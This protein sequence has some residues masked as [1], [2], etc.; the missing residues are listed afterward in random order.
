MKDRNKN[1]LLIILI[2]GILS[3]TIAYASLSTKLNIQG[4]AN[5]PAASWNIHFQNWALDTN[6][7]VNGRVNR[8]E[9]P[10][11]GQLT[12]SLSPN[13]TKIDDMIVTFNAPGD[14]VKYTFQIKNSGSINASL[15]NFE[16]NLTCNDEDCSML[17]YKIECKDTASGG[18]NVLEVGSTLLSNEVAYCSLEL[19]YKEQTN[20][21]TPGENQIYSQSAVSAEIS[22][23]WVYVQQRKYFTYQT[24]SGTSTTMPSTRYYVRTNLS[25]GSKEVC[26]VFPNGT[27]CLVN[28]THERRSEYGTRNENNNFIVIGYSEEKRA[29]MAAAGASCS[30]GSNVVNCGN[31]GV[32]C[33]LDKYGV[34]YC[35]EGGNLCR[36]TTEG[37]VVCE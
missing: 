4:Q 33:G 20:N 23:D 12:Q 3:I 30:V 21:S 5:I 15:D 11:V 35:S 31:S 7:T 1:V 19:R 22:A 18:K 16:K 36:L 17:E 37:N 2:V 34:V 25:T 28:D 32:Q 24:S 29:E 10:T 9:Y 6:N 14:Y 27:V 13:I 26:G 8:A